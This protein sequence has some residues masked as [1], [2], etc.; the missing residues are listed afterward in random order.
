ML[1][2][3]YDFMLFFPIVVAIYF[4]VPKKVRYIWLLLASY[5]FYM[6]WNAKYAILIG[7]ST[8]ITY[9]SGLLIERVGDASFKY[10]WGGGISDLSLRSV[11]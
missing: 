11:L 9:L 1:F 2:N 4:F 10:T 3:S 8:L 6:G 5:Y 7:I